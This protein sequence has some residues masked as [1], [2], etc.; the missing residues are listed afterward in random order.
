MSVPFVAFVPAAHEASV[1]VAVAKY[2]HSRGDK[3]TC[4]QHRLVLSSHTVHLEKG[5]SLRPQRYQMYSRGLAA[6]KMELAVIAVREGKLSIRQAAE[7]YGIPPTSRLQS[8][9]SP[10]NSWR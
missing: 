2:Y 9:F 3:S 10:D 4:D 7:K 6:T 1:G 5:V 8:R